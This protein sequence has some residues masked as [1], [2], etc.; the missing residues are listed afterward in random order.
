MNTGVGAT[1]VRGNPARVG[2]SHPRITPVVT[3]LHLHL[4]GIQA[5]SS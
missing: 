3:L 4:L 2:R 1:S 5:I